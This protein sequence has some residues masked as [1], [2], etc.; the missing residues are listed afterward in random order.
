MSRPH[1]LV[2]GAGGH[3]SVVADALIAGG[4]EVIAFIDREPGA[5]LLGRPVLSEARDLAGFDRT[6]IRLAIGVGGTRG[7]VPGTLRAGLIKRLS[8]EG[9]M[10][11]DVIHPAA[12]LSPS[13]RLG[14]G[15]QL[16]ARAVM[17]PNAQI[18][19]GTIVNTAAV[20]EHDAIVGSHCHISIGAILCGGVTVGA[21]SHIGAGACVRE[22]VTI[23]CDVTIGMGAVVL[24]D[25]PD[26]S[27]FFGN[28][29]REA[30]QT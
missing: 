8:G 11:A 22:G 7:K 29:A 5:E 12:T 3:A 2:I 19:D 14:Q 27:I 21:N 28:P 1:Y 24:G 10:I 25:C 9:W 30:N 4:G 26:G 18:G 17:Q 13:T 23:G 16:M 20:V 6:L 15:V